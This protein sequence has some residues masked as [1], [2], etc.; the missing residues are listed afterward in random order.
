MISYDIVVKH[1][2][3]KYPSLRIRDNEEDHPILK[4]LK[5]PYGTQPIEVIA[6]GTSD[7]MM[8]ALRKYYKEV[9]N[10]LDTL[11]QKELYKILIEVIIMPC[12]SP[13]FTTGEAYD[14]FMNTEDL[15]GRI[16]LIKESFP[17]N[18]LKVN[19]SVY[20]VELKRYELSKHIS[21]V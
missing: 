7:E 13:H 1:L 3:K 15:D 10:Y 6:V 5:N 18:F 8:E 9:N 11:T 12:P 2:E 17:P 4:D 20:Y 21:N 16:D 19:I 14:E